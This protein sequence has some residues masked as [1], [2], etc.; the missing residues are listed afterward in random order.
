[1]TRLVIWFSLATL[2][3]LALLVGG[4]GFK[5]LG[6]AVAFVCVVRLRDAL[7]H[8]HLEK[9]PAWIREC[10]GP[11]LILGSVV[12]LYGRLLLGDMPVNHD[13]PVFLYRAYNTGTLFLPNFSLAGFSPL[14]FAG[15]PANSLYPIGTDLLVCLLRGLTFGLFSWETA[16]CWA[17][18]LFVLSYP[19]AVYAL[20]RRFAGH[21]AGLAAG[22]LAVVDRGAWLQGGW[23]FN[24]DWGVW[25]MGL[26]F[27]LCLWALWMLDRLLHRPSHWNFIAT[28]SLFAGAVLC[29]P[30]GLAILGIIIPVFLVALFLCGELPAPG[31]WLPRV[32]SSGLLGFGL[33]AFWLIPFVARSEWLEPLAYHWLSIEEILRGLLDGSVFI[34][35]GPGLL[36]AGTIGLLLAAKRR[37]AFACFLLV[38]SGLLL[39][40]SSSSFLL[41]F[42]VLD[43]FPSL[44]NLQMERFAYFVR[45][46]LLIGCGFLVQLLLHRTEGSKRER[47]G[48]SVNARRLVLG[49]AIAPFIVFLPRIGP[50]PYLAPSK[51]LTWSSESTAYRDLRTAADF[52]NRQERSDLGRIAVKSYKHDHLLVALPVYTGLG[53]FKLGFTPE[54]NYR[55]K[56]DSTDPSVFKALNIS[57]LLSAGPVRRTDMKEIQRF[58][59]LYLYE[60][61]GFEG[62]RVTVEG[63]G[64]ARV[65]RDDPEA[66]DIELSQTGPSSSIIIHTARYALWTAEMNEKEVPIS[67]AT[68]GDSPEIF[69]RLPAADG[70]LKLRYEAGIPEWTGRILTLLAILALLSIC[71]AR[72]FGGFQKRL[73]TLLL[74]LRTPVADTVTLTTLA[75]S[76]LGVI[77]TVIRL[78]LPSDPVLIE[79][80]VV[81][82][83]AEMLPQ[84]RAEVIRSTGSVPCQPFD[85][86]RIKCPGPEWNYAGRTIIVA[87]HLLRDCIWLHPIQGARFSLVFEDVPLGDHIQGY[88]GM[89][90]A[91]VDPPSRHTVTFHVMLD[92]EELERFTCPSRRGWFAWSVETPGRLGGRGTVTVQSSAP[93]TG[94]RHFCFTAYATSDAD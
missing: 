85:G 84:A 24:L 11:V 33:C 18:F 17:L 36:I 83:F 60:F 86:K 55:F 49:A 61:L 16:Y 9:I 75:V 27:S 37:E 29:H 2:S 79:R 19:L 32:V 12:F 43:K 94:R 22:L 82:D 68:L 90:D 93:F 89:D 44:S 63:P 31:K 40:F 48:T 13:H 45:T 80:P 69:M 87:D 81:A 25:S 62:S 15:Y 67:G 47:P 74:P 77:Y 88:F 72:L 26:S 52:L 35:F 70:L 51:T 20:G 46:A 66:M 42:D 23:Q 3:F 14:M 41:T 71:S 28:G 91:A 65:L 78:L 4:D 73:T 7:L 50:L 21:W 54:N 57:H 30:M 6:A 1:M 58:G 5:I 64:V 76:G 56:F 8:L 38:T 10:A 34:Q 59:R 39:F 92:G 53:I